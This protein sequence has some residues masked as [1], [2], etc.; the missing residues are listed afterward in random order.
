MTVLTR[1]PL[2]L[3]A[4]TLIGIPCMATAAPGTSSAAQATIPIGRGHG[5]IW[6]QP[7]RDGEGWIV[8]ILDQR[9]A[10]LTWFTYDE[11]GAQRWLFA[12]GEIEG[13]AQIRFDR[14]HSARGGVFGP[15]FDPAAVQIE[16]VG[17]ARLSFAGCDDGTFSFEAFGQSAS[18]PL[19]RLTRTMAADCASLHGTPGEPVQP[20]AT[21]S[22]SW[23]D[24]ARNGEGFQL[25]WSADGTAVMMWYSFDAD[26]NPYWMVGAGQREGERIVFPA[27][28]TTHGGRFGAAF[29]P[30]AVERIDWGRLEFEIDCNA[31]VARYASS[32]PGFGS[33][34]LPIVAL[35]HA[36]AGPCPWTP[37]RLTDLYDLEWIPLPIVSGTPDDVLAT[38]VADDGTVAGVHNA[39]RTLKRWRP[40]DATWE[41]LP[42]PPL[43][44]YSDPA[45]ISG[46]ASLIYANERLDQEPDGTYRPLLWQSAQGLEPLPGFRH[47]KSFLL[48]V[49]QDASRLAGV[50]GNVT[51][52]WDNDN[53]QI[54]I[55]APAAL[56]PSAVSD[57]G[58][59]VV[60]ATVRFVQNIYPAPVAAI[61]RDG[62]GQSPMLDDN[63]AELGQPSACNHDC[64]IVFGN[65]SWG[66]RPEGASVAWIRL[67]EG[68]VSFLPMPADAVNVN[69]VDVTADGTLAVGAMELASGTPNRTQ[70]LL[71]TQFTGNV[72]VQELLSTLAPGVAWEE[73]RAT[74]VSP[75]GHYMLLAGHDRTLPTSRRNHAALLR[76][77][78]KVPAT[79]AAR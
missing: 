65:G 71:W 5:A 47:A 63:G 28:Q 77:V 58:A 1:W 45:W 36:V 72:A 14:L 33:G 48:T 11:A 74:D 61:W 73:M 22:G 8:E 21:E 50:S 13:D 70:A 9:T 16:T 64:S 40:G 60:G 15:G 75:G 56:R 42:G 52:I 26:G 35:T 54:D 20:W 57:D 62:H 24:P 41:T 27:L 49:S 44:G 79:D 67:A 78:P 23:Y 68:A 37:P 30:A 2:A 18:Y 39:S 51:W 12:V 32:L 4:F 29:D 6:Y 17:S 3:F 34:E 46:D 66:A 55:P 19:T 53:G 69:V 7:E 43:W 31:G 25:Q 76:L 59:T 10:T 38:S